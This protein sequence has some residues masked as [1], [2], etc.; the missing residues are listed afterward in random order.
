[1]DAR[2][3]GE[4]LSLSHKVIWRMPLNSDFGLKFYNSEETVVQGYIGFFLAASRTSM[5]CINSSHTRKVVVKSRASV[6]GKS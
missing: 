2:T 3:P 6:L 5:P 4:G 1:M